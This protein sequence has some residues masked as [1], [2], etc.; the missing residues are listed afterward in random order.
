[1][2]RQLTGQLERVGHDLQQ[3]KDRL[4]RMQVDNEQRWQ[5]TDRGGAASPSP[6]APVS[7]ADSSAP[8]TLGTLG[9]S[10]GANGPAEK[11]Y[12][13]AFGSVRDSNYAEAERRFREFLGR[14]PGH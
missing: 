2:Q 12:E 10:A 4:D 3:L 5:Q 8:G 11:L 14:Y 13:Q 7:A 9:G 1:Q 6:S